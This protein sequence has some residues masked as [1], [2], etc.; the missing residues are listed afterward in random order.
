MSCLEEQDSAARL[1][2]PRRSDATGGSA[3]YYNVIIVFMH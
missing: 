1:H 3:T 2:Q